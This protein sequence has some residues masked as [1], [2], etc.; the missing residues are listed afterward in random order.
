MMITNK[1]LAAIILAGTSVSLSCSFDG[2]VSVESSETPE[3]TPVETVEETQEAPSSSVAI[4][5]EAYETYDIQKNS[6]ALTKDPTLYVTNEFIPIGNDTVRFLHCKSYFDDCEY[7]NSLTVKKEGDKVESICYLDISGNDLIIEQVRIYPT[8]GEYVDYSTSVPEDKQ[9]LEGAQRQFD[10]YLKQI[11]NKKEELR[12]EEQK[13]KD[14]L[15]Q[16]LLE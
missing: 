4:T 13:Q 3:Q 10:T 7:N 6:A 12:L 15:G 9:Y 11:L 8:K 2:Q 5:E 16:M 1:T 14:A